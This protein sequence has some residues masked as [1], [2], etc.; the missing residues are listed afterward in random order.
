MSQAYEVIQAALAKA[1]MAREALAAGDVE[2]AV[3]G[4]SA[5]AGLAAGVWEDGQAPAEAREQA[6]RLA[7][8]SAWLA[9]LTAAHQGT[10]ASEVLRVATVTGVAIYESG[11]LAGDVRLHGL[12]RAQCAAFELG[13]LLLRSDPS[14]ASELFH[15]AVQCSAAAKSLDTDEVDLG[16]LARVLANSAA[17]AMELAALGPPDHERPNSSPAD[18]SVGGRRALLQSAADLAREAVGSGGLSGEL[19]PETML[20]LAEACYQ[21]ALTRVEPQPALEL[22][23]DALGWSRR[24]TSCVG[25]GGLL[26]ARAFKNAAGYACVYG[27][28]LRHQDLERG[29]EAMQGGVELALAAAAPEGLPPH[30]RSEAYDTAVRTQQNIGLLLK[31]HDLLRAS[32]AFHQAASQA[33]VAAG[34]D[35]LPPTWVAGF[36]YLAANAMLEEGAVLL[37]LG[38]EHQSSARAALEDACGTAR[39]VLNAEVAEPEVVARAALVLCYAAGRIAEVLERHEA[40]AEPHLEAI[41]AAGE[42]AALTEGASME[43]RQHGA[44]LAL[45]AC[46]QLV[47]LTSVGGQKILSARVDALESIARK[48]R[49]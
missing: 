33:V 14:A 39:K 40:G 8:D 45:D 37:E 10:G 36:L 3:G 17:G 26:Q 20:V 25:S 18:A 48:L 32:A 5:A 46:R 49:S 42:R 9:G 12:Y 2:T 43:H 22:L 15:D 4:Y 6:A 1:R 24:A 31:E 30:L 34:I 27:L 21:L 35:K 38:E 41:I 16:K 19:E 7:A 47:A 13:H 11:D 28:T 44:E 29:I 23:E